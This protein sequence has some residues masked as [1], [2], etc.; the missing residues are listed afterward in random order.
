M[1]G[2]TPKGLMNFPQINQQSAQMDDFANCIKQNRN[3]IV[4]G[5]MGMQDMRIVKAIYRSVASGKRE[6]IQV[7][8]VGC[9]GKQISSILL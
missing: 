8:C 5:E 7:A 1:E 6:K 2:K 9:K 3:T 4:P